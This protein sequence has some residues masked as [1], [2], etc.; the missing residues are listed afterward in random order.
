VA[1][2]YLTLAGKTVTYVLRVSKR[3]RH[4]RL[5]IGRNGVLTVSA[6]RRVSLQFIERCIIDRSSWVLGKLKYFENVKR[7]LESGSQSDYLEHRE[8]ARQ[9][10]VSRITHFNSH[11]NFTIGKIVIRNQQTRWGSCSKK[12]NLNFNYRLALISPELADYVIVHELCHLQEFNHSRR[13]WDLV[14]QTIPDYT[15]RR[16]QLKQEGLRLL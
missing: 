5:S 1:T 13:F 14:A 4:L 16:R 2:H 11:Y 12:G 9:L 7:R 3:A 8:Q 15:S 10:V 6:P